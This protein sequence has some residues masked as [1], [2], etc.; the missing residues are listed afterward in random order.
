MQTNYLISTSLGDSILDLDNTCYVQVSDSKFLKKKAYDVNVGDIVC[1]KKPFAK[2]TLEDIESFFPRSPRYATA[3]KTIHESNSA[4]DYVPKLRTHLIRG[5]AQQGIVR[6]ESLEDKILFQDEDFSLQQYD[7]MSAYLLDLLGKNGIERSEQAMRNWL[8][9]DTLAPSDWNIF[10]VLEH[11]NPEFGKFQPYTKEPYSMYFNYRLYRG[12]RQGVM[13][14]LNEFR[15]TTEGSESSNHEDSFISISPEYA[16]ILEHFITDH[17]LDYAGARVTEVAKILKRAQLDHV[18]KNN[19]ALGPGIV[20]ETLQSLEARLKDYPSVADDLHVLEKFME[21][22]IEDYMDAS[23]KFENSE[24]SLHRFIFIEH[25][26]SSTLVYTYESYKEGFDTEL[27]YF[28]LFKKYPGK[29]LYSEYAK[30][31]HEDMM[32]GNVDHALD[33]ERGAMLKLFEAGQ[34]LR[35]LLPDEYF[36]CRVLPNDPKPG[37]EKG[38]L[39]REPKLKAYGFEFKNNH[40]LKRKGGYFLSE[41][42]DKTLELDPKKRI[43]ENSTRTLLKQWSCPDPIKKKAAQQ[44]FGPSLKKHASYFFDKGARLRSREEVGNILREYHLGNLIFLREADFLWEKS[45]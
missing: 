15:G 4:G 45:E 41:L 27:Q 31:I 19:K 13:R 16:I 33:V 2:T 9:G 34:R 18:M 42:I 5:L 7:A 30:Q 22:A 21:A 23:K 43:F 29:L 26:L 44:F 40:L 39:L 17:N 14:K 10:R 28:Q 20:T 32:L 6:T 11:I 37:W 3:Q 38:M 1:F 8:H 35:R 36:Q 25:V 24:P 12:I